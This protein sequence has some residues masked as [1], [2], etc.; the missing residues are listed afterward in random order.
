MP[1]LLRIMV[2]VRR[3]GKMRGNFGFL[4]EMNVSAKSHSTRPWPRSTE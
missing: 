1:T 3:S 4:V 2:D